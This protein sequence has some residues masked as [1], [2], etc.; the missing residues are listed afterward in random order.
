M[1]KLPRIEVKMLP[2]GYGLE[3]EGMKGDGYLYFSPEKLLEGFMMH[4]GLGITDQLNTETMQDFL[5][6]AMNWRDNE[7]CIKE[8]KTLQDK[9][10]VLERR[11]ESF[12]KNLRVERNNNAFLRENIADL[13]KKSK[14]GEDISKELNSLLNTKKRRADEEDV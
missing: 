3:F 10:M 9:I 4:I 11:V 2:N 1:S 6:T 5:V 7:K 8:I 12:E 14:R 13:A